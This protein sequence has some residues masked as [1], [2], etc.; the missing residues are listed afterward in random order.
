MK[1]KIGIIYQKSN[2]IGYGHYVRSLRLAKILK[3]KYIVNCIELKKNSEILSKIRKKKYNLHLFDLKN[4]SKK[5]YKL[6]NVL[7]FENINQ[8]LKKIISIN[9]LDNDLPNSGPEYFIY[10]ESFKNKKKK[11]KFL[12][13]KLNI[14]VVQGRNDSNNQL[15]K[16]IKILI[17]NKKKI[18]FDF[19]I[20]VKVKKSFNIK[21]N[22]LI[23]FLPTFKNE[24]DIYKNI[25]L[26]ISGVGNTAYELGYLGIPTI[27]FSAEKREVNRAKFFHKKKL[28]PYIAPGKTKFIINE[29][30]KFYINDK[31]RKKIIYNRIRFF[32]RNNKISKFINEII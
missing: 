31:Y 32:K 7:V 2:K 22:N 26:A 5:I 28:A 23:K 1:K 29:L 25:D 12:K 10:P 9:P 13:K 27:H 14:L 24:Y 11:F 3:K 8:K 21:K 18:Q 15:K 6:K 30:N 4:Y 17:F 19:T 16:L 20:N